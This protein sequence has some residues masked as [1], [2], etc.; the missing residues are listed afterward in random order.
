M[1]SN[2][3]KQANSLKIL[4]R[5]SNINDV[6]GLSENIKNKTSLESSFDKPKFKFL[7]DIFIVG[8][9]R[10][11]S[12]LIES[13]LGMNN[14]VHNL[15]ESGILLNALIES[16]KSNFS[17]IDRNYFKYSQNFSSNKLTTNKMLSNYMQFHI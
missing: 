2:F 7:R 4:D 12:T 11:G 17:E 15:G 16:E 6:I 10:S 5:P 13:I 14:D 3:L 1:S 9:P 8:L